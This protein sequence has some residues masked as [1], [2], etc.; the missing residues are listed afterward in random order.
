MFGGDASSSARPNPWP[1]S[2]AGTVNGFGAPTNCAAARRHVA[3]IDDPQRGSARVDEGQR[4]RI[5]SGRNLRGRRRAGEAGDGCSPGAMTVM[6]DCC[7][8]SCSA[9]K[10]R[11]ARPGGGERG[12]RAAALPSPIQILKFPPAQPSPPTASFAR[13]SMSHWPDPPAFPADSRFRRR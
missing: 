4:C 2:E 13:G 3:K 10:A 9:G 7:A 12:L 11:N 1:I 8:F 5:V 6:G